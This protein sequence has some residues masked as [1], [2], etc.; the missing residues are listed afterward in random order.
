MRELLSHIEKLISPIV[1]G[2]GFELVEVAIAGVG[3]ST[4]IRVFVYSPGGITVGDIAKLSGK[5]S[6]TLDE[7]DI[8]QYRY[9][10]EVSSPGLDRPLRS[11]RDFIRAISEKVRIIK[12]SGDTIEGELQSADSEKLIIST[13]KGMVEVPFTQVAVGKIIF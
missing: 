3:N 11:V 7:S 12:A 5:I 2:E 8:I 10:L 4:A 6:R 13:V 1:E 9:F